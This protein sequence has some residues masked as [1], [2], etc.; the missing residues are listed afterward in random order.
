MT[1]LSTPDDLGDDLA[2]YRAE[3]AA[4]AEQVDRA[5]RNGVP[6]PV[7]GDW[8]RTTVTLRGVFSRVV[9]ARRCN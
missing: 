7:G 1:S 3:A 5:A 9:E 8:L 6:A 2:S 4:S